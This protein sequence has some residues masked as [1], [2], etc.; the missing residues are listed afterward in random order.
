LIRQKV[1]QYF[2]KAKHTGLGHSQYKLLNSL[3]AGYQKAIG[4]V[5]LP[6]TP[7]NFCMIRKLPDI[8]SIPSIKIPGSTVGVNPFPQV[9]SSHHCLRSSMSL[10]LTENDRLISEAYRLERLRSYFGDTLRLCDLQ[11]NKQ[12][13]LLIDCSQPWI[14]DQLMGEMNELRWYAWVTVGVHSVALYFAG[15]KVYATATT[16]PARKPRQRPSS[17]A[18]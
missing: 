13:R 16:K 2:A 1:I 9:K 18:G 12:N 3:I 5:K 11:V 14:V 4:A 7:S 10:E 6:Q 17:I 15:V 8:V